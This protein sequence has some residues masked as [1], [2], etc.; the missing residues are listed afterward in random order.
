MMSQLID[1]VTEEVWRQGHDVTKPDG[2]FRVSW[3]LEAWTTAMSWSGKITVERIRE[4]GVKVE[5]IKNLD[6]FRKC[7]VFVGGEEKV[8]HSEIV[9]RLEVLVKGH[10]KPL[11]FYREFEE[12]HPFVDGNGR[13]GKILLNYLN[14]T[15]E[16]PVFPPNDFWG[17]PIRNP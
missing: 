7:A 8:Y 9:H 12:I 1:Y 13:T 15:L 4:T 2:L 17:Y 16:N 6:G 11:K 5:Q 3:M 10:R 14:G